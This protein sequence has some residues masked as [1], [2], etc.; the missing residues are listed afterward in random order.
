[1]KKR[2]SVKKHLVL[3]VYTNQWK[4]VEPVLAN[5]FTEAPV[6]LPSWVPNLTINDTNVMYSVY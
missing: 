6:P 3:S 2:F 5:V 4:N 1:M